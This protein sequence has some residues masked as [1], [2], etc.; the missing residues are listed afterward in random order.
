[1]ISLNTLFILVFGKFLPFGMTC[2]AAFVVS[3]SRIEALFFLFSLLAVLR[4]S[5]R[6]VRIENSALHESHVFRR[7]VLEPFRL[8]D[9]RYRVVHT[10]PIL[11]DFTP[12][13]VKD[14]LL[15]YELT[16]LILKYVLGLIG[17]SECAI[18]S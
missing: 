14:Q 3:I 17:F 5:F 13:K 9:R 7:L 12:S 2:V 18:W 8:P 1:M 15:S 6:R 16:T 4:R 11:S 10:A